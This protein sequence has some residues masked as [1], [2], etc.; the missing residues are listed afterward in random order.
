MN[1]ILI[2][3]GSGYVGTELIEQLIKKNKVI[4]YDLDLFGSDHL[5]YSSK[6]FLH[7]RGDIRDINKIKKILKI[8]KPDICFHL[9]C[10]SNDPSFLLNENLSKEIN[11]DSF[12]DFLK[13]INNTSLNKLI[14]ASTSSVY[15]VSEEE[16]ITEDYP[17][18]PITLYN[19]YKYECEKL[20]VDQKNSFKSC[21][22]R[23]AT[24]CGLSSKMRFDLTV[25]ILTNFAYFKKEIKV[26]GGRQKRPNIHINDMINLYIS[27]IDMKFDTFDK[28]AFNAGVENLSI[29]TIAKKVQKIMLDKKQLNVDIKYEKTDD[30]R[31]YHVNSDK[32]QKIL[33]FK[34]E[35]NVDD[36]INDLIDYFDRVKPSD[37]FENLN[38][39][40]AKKLLH[41][42]FT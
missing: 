8:Y 9:A 12:K 30:I 3:G 16:D 31:S 29:D 2:L 38:Y 22:I 40:N 35:K 11:Y 23:P 14:F 4:N 7:I 42:K 13:I 25:N 39:F 6:N 32:I 41:T 24:V 1:T 33:K 28:Q 20:I 19:R 27:L 15:G 26:F 34:F 5:P 36:A 37:T 21:I 10:I 17:K 18:K